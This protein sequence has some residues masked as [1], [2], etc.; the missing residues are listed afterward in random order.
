MSLDQDTLIATYQQRL[1]GADI[2]ALEAGPVQNLAS[3]GTSALFHIAMQLAELN[4]NVKA[5]TEAIQS[6]QPPAPATP[7]KDEPTAPP[8]KS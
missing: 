5:L 7:A 2:S 6:Q 4:Q 8:V 1:K 3:G